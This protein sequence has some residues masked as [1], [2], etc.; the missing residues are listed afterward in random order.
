MCSKG[1]KGI[2]YYALIYEI[3][4]MAQEEAQSTTL[5]PVGVYFKHLIYGKAENPYA[6]LPN[7]KVT[8]VT[9]ILSEL[10]LG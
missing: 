2:V 4:S 6:M 5:R 10:Y 8:D 3:A 1:E 9:V 7:G